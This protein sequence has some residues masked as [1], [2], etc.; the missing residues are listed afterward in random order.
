V[1]VSDKSDVS[2]S[3]KSDVSHSM[4]EYVIFTGFK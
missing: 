4:G 1:S 3:D 2:V